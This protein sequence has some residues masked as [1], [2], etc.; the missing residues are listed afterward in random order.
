MEQK[1]GGRKRRMGAMGPIKEE[2]QDNEALL[3]RIAELEEQLRE[4]REAATRSR[5]ETEEARLEC[6][7]LAATLEC[8][9][10]EIALANKKRQAADDELGQLKF[11]VRIN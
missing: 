11:K 3:R 2:Q 6:K 4:E 1:N 10:L 7:Q 8:R 5:L 9:D